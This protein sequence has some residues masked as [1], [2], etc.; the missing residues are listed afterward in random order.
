[1]NGNCFQ[2]EDRC[3]KII[4][5]VILTVLRVE[6]DHLCPTVDFDVIYMSTLLEA[7]LESTVRLRSEINSLPRYC[8]MLKSWISVEGESRKDTPPGNVFSFIR[9]FVK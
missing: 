7:S 9:N 6:T 3:V 1:M 2:F 8:K 5:Q 4:R